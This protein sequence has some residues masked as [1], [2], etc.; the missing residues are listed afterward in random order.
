M[1]RKKNYKKKTTKTTKTKKFFGKT[2]KK[3][4]RDKF[5]KSMEWKTLRYDVLRENES[6]CQICGRVAG[7][8]SK[9][10]QKISME[11]DH[12]LPVSKFWELRG[13]RKNLMCVCNECNRGK[14]ALVEDRYLW[15][16]EEFK[17]DNENK[18]EDE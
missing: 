16:L 6:R 5:F 9:S 14:D 8:V 13:Y 7:E 15:I 18:K 3:R 4:D 2:K 11:V 12:I 17:K 1:R 10:G